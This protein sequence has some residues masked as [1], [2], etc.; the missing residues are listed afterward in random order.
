MLQNGF[1]RAALAGVA[2]FGIVLAIAMTFGRTETP[3]AL[4]SPEEAAAG[5]LRWPAAWS[6][7]PRYTSGMGR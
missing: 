5:C 6:P 4:G 3:H 2:T 7:P 1:A